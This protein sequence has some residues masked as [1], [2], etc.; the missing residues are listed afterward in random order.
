ML[1]RRDS[2]AWLYGI[3]D[4]GVGIVGVFAIARLYCFAVETHNS[5]SPLNGFS[6]K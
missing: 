5:P 3:D 6:L 4:G 2:I 1:L